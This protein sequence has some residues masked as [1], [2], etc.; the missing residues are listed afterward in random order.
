MSLFSTARVKG[1]LG[2]GLLLK[3]LAISFISVNM[4]Q[5][6]VLFPHEYSFESQVVHLAHLSL[7]GGDKTI[8]VGWREVVVG[9]RTMMERPGS[10]RTAEKLG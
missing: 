10:G 8:A 2:E 1:D 7:P 3:P 4:P 5:K 9:G 6:E